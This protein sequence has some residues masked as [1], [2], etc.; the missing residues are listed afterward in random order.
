MTLGI[1]QIAH[2]A[3]KVHD[4]DR[5][6]AFY[7]D[8]LGFAEMLR[9][10]HSEGPPEGH[11]SLVYLRVTDAQYLELFPDGI[12]ARVADEKT[13]C[14]THI[15]LQ[16]DSISQTA[17]ELQRLGVQLYRPEKLGLDGNAQCWIL[18]PDGNRIELMEMLPGN[19]QAAAIQRLKTT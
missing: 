8:T 2:W 14:M 6:L 16:V 12:G 11:F 5:S 1:S 3:L 19:M 18:D 7:R 17:A 10:S 15:C 9:I 13:T 4:F